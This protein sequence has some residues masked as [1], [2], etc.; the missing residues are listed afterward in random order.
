MTTKEI[1]RVINDS[2]IR[3]ITNFINKAPRLFPGISNIEILDK[4]D[5]GF[6]GILST[7]KFNNGNDEIFVKGFLYPTDNWSPET[8]GYV[9]GWT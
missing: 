4:V 5:L 7:V 3:S 2:Y 1:I 8:H 9:I 6:N